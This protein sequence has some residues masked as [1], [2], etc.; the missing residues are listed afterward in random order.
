MSG[1]TRRRVRHHQ[2]IGAAI[3]RRA[4]QMLRQRPADQGDNGFGLPPSGRVQPR[5]CTIE[6][7]RCLIR[8]RQRTG[9]IH[10]D[11]AALRAA[12]LPFSRLPPPHRHSTARL[13]RA[14]PPNS[15]LSPPECEKC[16]LP[17]CEK[18][19]LASLGPERRRALASV[20]AA[21]FAT[22]KPRSHGAD[23][24]RLGRLRNTDGRC[25][26]ENIL[27]CQGLRPAKSTRRWTFLQQTGGC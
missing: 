17:E 25:L 19:G 14:S 22:P 15:C 26:W 3:H 7:R 12:M 11:N 6:K 8:I 24:Y 9:G 16:L 21:L 13:I 5:S 1:V 18:C 20:H 2:H 23:D 10:P 27:S 4:D